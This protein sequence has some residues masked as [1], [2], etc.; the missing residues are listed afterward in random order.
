M[1][2]SA[3]EAILAGVRAPIVL[4]GLNPEH[5]YA[6]VPAGTTAIDLSKLLGEPDHIDQRVEAL[7]V[8]SFCAY[9]ARFGTGDTVIFANESS[10]SYEAVLDYH[11]KLIDGKVASSRGEL[12][13]TL[14]Y[15]CPYSDQWKTWIQNSGKLIGQEEFAQFIEANVRD[16]NEPAGADMLQMTLHLQV[17]KS[18]QFES[19]I[20]LDNGQVQ[21]RYVEAI[22]G[23]TGTKAG[24]LEIPTEFKLHLPVFVDGAQFAQ[25]ARFKYRMN[26]GKLYLGYELIRPS[27]VLQAAVKQVTAEIIKGCKAHPVFR[28][29]RRS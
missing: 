5:K 9:L 8:E 15:Q 7:S 17:H 29:Q 20:R 13:H 22:K 6:L 3:V 2:K 16:I 23:T 1:D 27:E 28:G 14:H 11:P 4:D 25:P 24:D 18:A 12:D 19:G 21:F 10:A 26:E